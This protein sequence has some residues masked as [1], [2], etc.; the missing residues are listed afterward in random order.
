MQYLWVMYHEE[1]VYNCVATNKRAPL[2]FPGERRL[3]WEHECNPNHDNWASVW[4]RKELAHKGSE[5]LWL[6]SVR[7]A[8]KSVWEKLAIHDCSWKSECQRTGPWFIFL[9]LSSIRL[10][11]WLLLIIPDPCLAFHICYWRA[12][13]QR[14]V[15]QE[16][17]YQPSGVVKH[18]DKLD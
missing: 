5:G 4:L 16:E 10:L 1:E 3:P 15:E 18:P 9:D 13:Y 7:K 2:Y 6:L 11:L 17:R 12:A 14:H 8:L